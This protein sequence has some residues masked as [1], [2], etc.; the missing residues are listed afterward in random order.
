MITGLHS[1]EQ[2][3]VMLMTLGILVVLALMAGSTLSAISGRYKTA[4]RTA[5]WEEALLTAES[6]VD[7]TVAQLAGLLPDVQINNGG[8]TL[9][10]STPSL[11]LLT[12]LQ[13]EP[14]G[15]D[16]ANGITVAINPDPLVHAGEGATVARATV[17]IDVLPLNEILNDQLLTNLLSLLSGSKASSVN[18]LRI[19]SRGTVELPG[20]SR[21]SDVSKLDADLMRAALVRDPVTGQKVT[22]PFVSREIEVLMKP[23]F[24]FDRGISSDG[25]INAPSTL[26]RF[27]SFNSGSFLGSTN[28]LF[29]SSKRRSN[30]AVSV[31]SAQV[32]IGGTVYGNVMTNGGSIV[33]DARITGLVDNSYFRPLPS[34]VAPNWTAMSSAVTGTKTI[35]A[36][37]LLAPVHLKYSEVNGTLRVSPNLVAILASLLNGIPIVSDLASS[38]VDIH[39]TGNFNGNLVVD[40]GVKVRLFV[41][42]DV[43]LAANALQNN[44]QRA[45]NV[46]I[47]GLPST[48]GATHSINVDTAGNRIAAIY[49]PNH[50]V[51]LGGNG[52]LSGAVSAASLKLTGNSSVHFD[53]ALALETSLVIGYELVSWKEN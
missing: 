13:L 34:V 45:T 53:E 15:L 14:G 36:G 31:N 44:T 35:N 7:I 21:A 17:S 40:P 5:A 6:A 1:R 43:N 4:Y 8:V 26:S 23:V 27:D 39:V 25:P 38:Q 19:R 33:K 42:G 32:A 24:P 52:S 11:A 12:G 16:L 30:I 46:Q 41:A 48:D 18:L 50:A 47:F 22:K 3:N 9:G 29:D 51:T 49:A 2:G 10:T 28:G 37:T 20:G